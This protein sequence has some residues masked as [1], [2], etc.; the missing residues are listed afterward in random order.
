[1]RTE[2]DEHRARPKEVIIDENIKFLKIMK[3]N[4]TLRL[5]QKT[6]HM[7]SMVLFR[8]NAFSVEY[9]CQNYR[10]PWQR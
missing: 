2:D 4:R 10:F 7:I 8:W 3:N 1:M 6:T 9:S 5:I